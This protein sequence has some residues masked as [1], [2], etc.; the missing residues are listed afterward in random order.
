MLSYVKSFAI[1]LGVLAM[2]GAVGTASADD[3]CVRHIRHEQHELD[4]AIAHHG[5]YSRQADHERREL[6]RI[7]SECRYR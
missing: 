4:K 2:F 7:R 5:Y 3:W 6:D 1:I